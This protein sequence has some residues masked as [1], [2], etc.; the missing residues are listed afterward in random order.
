MLS[1]IG[2]PIDSFCDR[3]SRRHFL[4]IGGLALGGLGLPQILRAQET[5]PLGGQ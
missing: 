1:I 3:S 5:A 2:R 4:K